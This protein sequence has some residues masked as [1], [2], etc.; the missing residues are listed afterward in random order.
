[1]LSMLKAENKQT[2]EAADPRALTQAEID[3]IRAAEADVTLKKRLL[4]RAVAE[5]P[6]DRLGRTNR[7]DPTLARMQTDL[8]IARQTLR[9]T[10]DRIRRAWHRRQVPVEIREDA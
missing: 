5:A 9:A 3:E 1:M 10:R 8:M 6:K 7:F 4:D 2:T